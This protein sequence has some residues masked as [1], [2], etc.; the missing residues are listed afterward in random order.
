MIGGGSAP[1]NYRETI[2]FLG[3]SAFTRLAPAGLAS[4]FQQALLSL[5]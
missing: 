1:V 2:D 4:G 5:L 3:A